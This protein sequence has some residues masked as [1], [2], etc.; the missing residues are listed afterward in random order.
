MLHYVSYVLAVYYCLVGLMYLG[1]G[2]SDK[3]TFLNGL[4][5]YRDAFFPVL[6]TKNLSEAGWFWNLI[7]IAS[8]G[9]G[10]NLLLLVVFWQIQ[11]LIC[12]L[13]AS[14]EVYLSFTFYKNNDTLYT[15]WGYARLLW[16]AG[17]GV[18][19]ILGTVGLIFGA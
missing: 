14:Y 19:I 16:N 18:S 8:A 2:L 7:G 4:K 3:V 9:I 10:L 1:F 11:V 6:A 12:F 17:I 13:I 5:A 15:G